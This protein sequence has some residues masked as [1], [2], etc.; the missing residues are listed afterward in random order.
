MLSKDNPLG[1]IEKKALVLLIRTANDIIRLENYLN[2]GYEVKFMSHHGKQDYWVLGKLEIKPSYE[3]PEIESY[4]V[5]NVR[6]NDDYVKETELLQ[7]EG[8]KIDSV[9]ST[10]AILIKYC[11]AGSTP[12][13]KALSVGLPLRQPL[14][15]K[16]VIK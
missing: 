8:Y 2:K 6:N 15:N 13:A 14:G 9:T 12:Y 4:R 1:E 16:E 3:R 7:K 11:L 5:I 10:T